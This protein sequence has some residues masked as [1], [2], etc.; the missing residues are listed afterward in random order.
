MRK[1]Y[2]LLTLLAFSCLYTA[3]SDNKEENDPNPAPDPTPSILFS[4][5]GY[6][7][8]GAFRRESK[9]TLYPLDKQLEQMKDRTCSGKVETDLGLYTFSDRLDRGDLFFEIQVTGN[10][11]NAIN[12]RHSEQPITLRAVNHVSNS[13]ADKRD[14]IQKIKL[15]TTNINI[16]TQ[17]TAARIRTL[18]KEDPNYYIPGASSE[19]FQNVSEK[20]AKEVLNAFSIPMVYNM[21]ATDCS[22]KNLNNDTAILTAISTTILKSVDE[23]L[24]DQ[25]FAEWDKDFAT[26]G[27]IDNEDIKE[28]ISYGQQNIEYA[29]VMKRLTNFYKKYIDRDTFPDFWRY[30]DR[31]GDGVLD[32]QDRPDDY[33]ITEEEF[34]PSQQQC[35][36][37]LVQINK[38]LRNYIQT[39]SVWEANFCG[40]IGPIPNYPTTLTPEKSETYDIWKNAY[41]TIRQCNYILHVLTTKEYDY[42]V[43]PY[44][45]TLYAIRS[46]LYLSLTQLFGDV[47]YITENMN[48]INDSRQIIRTPVKDIYT[49]QSAIMEKYVTS[50]P[51]AKEQDPYLVNS[52]AAH[53]LIATMYVEMKDYAN[54]DLQ[55][56]NTEDRYLTS[57]LWKVK[58]H[59]SFI[60][61]KPLYTQYFGGPYHNIYNINIIKFLRAEIYL[62]TNQLMKASDV[63]KLLDR[64][65]EGGNDANEI[66]ARLVKLSK[67]SIGEK[68]GY[69]SFLKRMEA[70]KEILHIEDYQLL[71]PIPSLEMENN[72]NISQNPG[73]QNGL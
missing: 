24:L 60:Y 28:S 23:E 46:L 30:I 17:L 13:V 40:V 4:I 2:L 63:L 25:F 67:H 44:I 39:E 27:H 6:A 9:V 21:Q 58:N 3:C 55:L 43:K 72:P 49:Q 38:Y 35:I 34:R 53:I 50:L 14:Y 51:L 18:L 56:N 66:K 16:M 45:G 10:F 54:A 20:A 71:L 41:L 15:P 33:D 5:D 62:A 42:D 73:Y 12:G 19:I 32:E 61:D 36:E 64:T 31:N 29:T 59:D 48:D 57:N 47:P 26:D 7:E 8:L 1:I 68:F 70:A 69:F 65:W 22:I 37:L 11:F 52:T